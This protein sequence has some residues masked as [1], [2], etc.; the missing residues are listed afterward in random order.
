MAENDDLLNLE[1]NNKKNLK[2]PLVYG[3]VAFL[4]FII[5]VLIFAIYS[6]TSNEDK[7]V[8]I[9]PEEKDEIVTNFKEIPIEENDNLVV[10]KLIESEDKQDTKENKE[11]E[12]TKT[13]KKVEEKPVVKEKV[14]TPKKE[15]KKIVKNY[16]IQVGA[17]IKYQKPNKRFLELIKKEGYN[18]KLHEI[19]Y[20]KDG[21]KVEVI[22]ILVGPFSKEEVRKELTKVKRKISKN[23]F[24]YRIK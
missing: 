2:K 15:T 10:K 3:A 23:A 14:K 8:V 17:L 19:S 22:K 7:S 1:Q 12:V 13:V 21:K 20:T 24:V 11:K 9:P 4:F 5:G 16:Y 18:Y 6:N